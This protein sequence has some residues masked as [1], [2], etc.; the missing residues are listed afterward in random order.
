[1]Q[2]KIWVRFSDGCVTQ[3]NSRKVNADLL[4]SRKDFHL[5]HISFQYFEANECKNISDSI[6]SIVNCAFQRGIIKCNEGITTTAEIVKIIRVEVKDLQRSSL[7]FIVEEFEAFSR[8]DA[9]EVYPLAGI[10]GIHSLTVHH[11]GILA[12]KL[13][14]MDCKPGLCPGCT[15]A[16]P[17]IAINL[18]TSEEHKPSS[19]AGKVQDQKDDEPSDLSSTDDDEDQEESQ[20]T[21]GDV[22]WAKHG[23]SWYPAEVVSQAD[24]PEN[25]YISLF[26]NK[27]D[28]LV[29]QWYG[30]KTFSWER[31]SQLNY[32]T[33]NRIDS[34]RAS[35]SPRMLLLYQEALSDLRMD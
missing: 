12:Q 1:M 8:D 22:V 3:F 7:F 19:A 4:K 23:Q 31:A 5:S 30:E 16:Q 25:L 13:S 14:C 17:S 24:V 32:F 10:L 20:F 6:G 33:E 26:R 29:V 34:Y 11:E 21:P 27:A 15:E 2:Y 18:S 28:E 35:K 9:E